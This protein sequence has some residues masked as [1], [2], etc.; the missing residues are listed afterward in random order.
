MPPIIDA[1]AL[2]KQYRLGALGAATFREEIARK[3]GWGGAPN[4][5]WALRD[6]SFQVAP[7]EVVGVIGRNGAGKS[8][9]LKIL[10]RITEPTSG[11]VRLRGRVASLLEIGTGFHP[12]LS[13]R[14]NIFVNGTILGMT[15]AEVRAKFD[16]IVAFADIGPFLDT[17]V[18]RYSSG[19]YVRLAFAVAAH[20]EQEILIVDE[21]L[22]VGD[23]AFQR[24]CLG[25][26]SDVSRE[27]GRTVLF[28]SH[29]MAAILN[30]C[31]R[32]LLLDAGRLAA[33]GPAGEVVH[34]YMDALRTRSVTRLEQRTDRA[35]TGTLRAVN[36]AFE[37]HAGA[38]LGAIKSGD[39][40][41]IAIDVRR[42]APLRAMQLAVTVRDTH[43]HPV[44]HL[45]TDVRSGDLDLGTAAESRA[46]VR[47][48]RLPLAPGT[49]TLSLAAWAGGD[50]ADAVE[51]AA[52]L[53]VHPG[54]FYGT[55]KLPPE[56]A[57]SV[58]FDY[59]IG[60]ARRA[61]EATA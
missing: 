18:K 2:S 53:D 44:A 41:A 58:L 4:A 6:V 60:L 35:G 37:D 21:V 56:G 51:A 27:Q 36:V 9:L 11:E 59:D 52:T 46:V 26:M 33:A 55:G 32:A 40:V 20:L 23:A 54:D 1:A 15:R 5:F 48:R 29:N 22:A 10:S 61:R 34:A 3:L 31:S 43:G 50:L 25:K 38:P 14:E 16:E 24:K 13:G 8:T 57:G 7:G 30:L 49:Y 47:I 39:D 17:P 42:H 28:V 19:M 45:G 12:D